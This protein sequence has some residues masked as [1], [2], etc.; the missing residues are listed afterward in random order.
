MAYAPDDRRQIALRTMRAAVV[1][2]GAP[3]VGL[4]F[5]IA[6]IVGLVIGIVALVI[7]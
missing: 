5:A 6:V 1:A 4:I 7:G 3:I 2:A